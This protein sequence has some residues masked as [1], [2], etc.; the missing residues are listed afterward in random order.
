MRCCG[1]E[2][3][4]VGWWSVT[5]E[6]PRVEG[7]RGLQK[8][9][10]LLL[11]RSRWTRRRC[12]ADR[13]RGGLLGVLLSMLRHRSWTRGAARTWSTTSLPPPHDLRRE[14]ADAVV[15]GSVVHPCV[16]IKEAEGP[17]RRERF[18]LQAPDFDPRV[19]AVVGWGWSSIG[20]RWRRLLLRG[21][22]RAIL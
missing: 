1:P 12:A 15:A 16:F 8:S 21:R 7:P 3:R 17:A 9:L 10:C 18:A 19:A 20:R 14:S 13:R 4:D 6:R 2:R 11:E 5:P 22:A